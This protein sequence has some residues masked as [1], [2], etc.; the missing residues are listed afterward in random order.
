MVSSTS[1]VGFYFVFF[2]KK[3]KSKDEEKRLTF[4]RLEDKLNGA[5]AAMNL[6]E[7]EA[8][9]EMKY[10]PGVHA[11]RMNALSKGKTKSATA[12]IQKEKHLKTE[13]RSSSLEKNAGEK[14][15]LG[16]FEAANVMCNIVEISKDSTMHRRTHEANTVSKHEKPVKTSSKSSI[17]SSVVRKSWPHFAN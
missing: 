7:K 6:K 9:A 4:D 8:K 15:G 17:T 10:S 11:E 16:L 13:N 2:K 14:V 3:S 5:V 1:L 12:I